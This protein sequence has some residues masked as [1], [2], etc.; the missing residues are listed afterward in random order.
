[1]LGNL[2]VRASAVL[3]L[4]EVPPSDV[5]LR[6]SGLDKQVAGALSAPAQGT[7]HHGRG[8]AAERLLTRLDVPAD[9]LDELVL[10]DIVA[11]SAGEGSDGGE[12]L[13]GVGQLPRPRLDAERGTGEAGV[14]AKGAHAP[15][16]LVD[17]EL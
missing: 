7:Q 2:L 13:A 12:L 6:D 11:L 17:E 5:L 1:M 15:A 4:G 3:G 8:L 16:L 10:V 9:L 14:V